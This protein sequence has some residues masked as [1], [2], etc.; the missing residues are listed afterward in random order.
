MKQLSRK[1]LDELAKVMPV[2]SEMEQRR[3]VGG[4]S[5]GYRVDLIRE[6]IHGTNIGL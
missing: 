4:N 5:G 2:I 3:F 1:N 6:L